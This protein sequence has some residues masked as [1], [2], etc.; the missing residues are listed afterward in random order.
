MTLYILLLLGLVAASAFFSGSEVA[1]FSLRRV[2]RE[3]LAKKEH[4]V[5]GLI[6][7]MVSH[8]RRLI[9]TILIGNECVNVAVGAVMAGLVPHIFT[10]R[11]E[12]QL[13]LIAT[14]FALPLLLLFGEITP[15]SVAIK[16]SV[17]WTRKAAR[18]L[19]L[20]AVLVTPIR[21]IVRVL[22][23]LVM[24]PFHSS[25]FAN[26]R[27]E[28]SEEE[29]RTLVDAGMAEGEVNLRERRLIQRV[30]E[31]GDKTVDQIMLSRKKIFALAYDLPA[32]RLVEEIARGGY[33]RVPIYQKSLDRIC[34][35]VYAKDLVVQGAGLSSP[36]KLSELLHEPLF[37]PRTIPLE[38]LFRLFKQRKIHM[39]IVV[40]EYGRV[41]GLITMED[42]LEELF[43]EISDEREQ[44]KAEASI[45]VRLTTEPVMRIV[46]PDDLD[47]VEDAS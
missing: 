16:T 37:V 25:T 8:P 29:F 26:V 2:D 15:K 38:R 42:L 44:Q 31:F 28:L 10:G 18:P 6:V 33:S 40:N 21:V 34:G 22:A 41:V 43:G 24:R 30:F 32:T 7:N 46:R 14:M 27:S 35:I 39:A 1:M 20:F 13:A 3:R 45:G 19:W 4:R 9:A 11:S 12:L 47:D 23:D 36:R 17:G 5:D